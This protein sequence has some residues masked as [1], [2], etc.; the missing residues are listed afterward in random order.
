MRALVNLAQPCQGPVICEQK[1]GPTF[2]VVLEVLNS[3]KSFLHLQ[4]VGG[5][6]FLKIGEF[7]TGVPDGM[8]VPFLV[9]LRENGSLPSRMFVR[10]HNSICC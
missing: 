4:V 9:D 5:I 10:S 2:K 7:P 1:E 8:M 3:P 6:V